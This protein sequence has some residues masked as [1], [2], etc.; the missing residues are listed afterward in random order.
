MAEVA[1]GGRRRELRRERAIVGGRVRQWVDF[2]KNFKGGGR[3][4]APRGADDCYEK[5]ARGKAAW[6][7]R[8]RELHRERH[9]EVRGR[10]D[11]QAG[12][13][14]AAHETGGV[15]RVEDRDNRGGRG[16]CATPWT[17]RTGSR[18]T[19]GHPSSNAPRSVVALLLDLAPAMEVGLDLSLAPPA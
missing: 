16:G 10:V 13:V 4:R 11:L 14:A 2:F 19:A 6:G 12:G 1:W 18:P 9:G 8:H 3:H 15:L 17:S 7:G 5:G